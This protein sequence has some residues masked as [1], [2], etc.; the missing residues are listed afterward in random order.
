MQTVKEASIMTKGKAVSTKLVTEI[1]CPCCGKAI[2]IFKETKTISPAQKAEKEE[3][4][5]A[6]AVK[7]L[8][9]YMQPNGP[10]QTEAPAQPA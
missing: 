9:E 8:S 4:F 1:E 2:K 5:Y 7:P 6:E 3:K 10:G